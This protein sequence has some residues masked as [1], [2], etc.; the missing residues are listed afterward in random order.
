MSITTGSTLGGRYT[1]G[2]LIAAGG[3]GDVWEAADEVLRRPVAVKVV[4]PLGP[5]PSFL[6]RFRDEARGSAALHHPN[7]AS[8]FDYGEEEGTAY[9]VMELV[10]GRTLGELI[11]ESGHG[12]VADDVRAILGQAAL[13][14]AAAHEAGVVHR[15]VKPANIIVT[16]EGQVKLTDF[17]IARLGDGSGHTA[18]GEVLGTPQYISPEQARGEPA[19]PTSDV[20]ALGV[21]A[22]EMLTGRNPFDRGTPV[23]TAFAQVNDDPPPLPAPVPA[24]LRAVVDSCLAKDPMGR[25]A[26]ARAVAEA[27][28]AAPE[29]VRMPSGVDDMAAGPAA[30]TTL[31]AADP[32]AHPVV[33]PTRAMTLG[34][35]RADVRRSQQ[36]HGRQH[37]VSRRW[38]WLA[39]PAV[40]IIAWGAFALGGLVNGQP[41]AGPSGTPTS[42]V[43]TTPKTSATAPPTTTAPQ[44]TTRPTTTTA[45]STRPPS[46]TSEAPAHPGK[47]K[48]RGKGN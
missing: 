16:P 14:L 29:T 26:D 2:A 15:D 42:G 37:H 8:V 39:V 32:T 4:R 34:P 25:P 27:I 28:G 44:T 35:R 11:R 6:D 33:E 41:A 7:I 40:G 13:A 45:T 19:G 24:D 18:T 46:S 10:P 17:G 22:Y 38:A 48:G 21:V 31:M 5:D 20:Y 30:T 1:L 9:L 43:P 23:A 3:M 36:V 47:G 12:L